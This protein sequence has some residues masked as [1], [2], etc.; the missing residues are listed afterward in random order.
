ME[1]IYEELE[2]NLA[3]ELQIHNSLLAAAHSFNNAIKNNDLDSLQKYTIVYDEHICQIEKL[4]EN[5]IQ[6]CK[7][8]SQTDS[9]SNK[10]V[11][12]DTILKTAP[13]NI[14][15]RIHEIRSSLKEKIKHLYRINTSNQILIQEAMNLI[16]TTFTIVGNSC[17]KLSPYNGKGK[18]S[19]HVSS[20][21]RI[22]NQ[23]A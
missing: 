4:E 23:I 8:L 3:Q 21:T 1:K 7:D 22:I 5:R 6:L 18:E 11:K 13:E 15:E 10:P 14:K 9:S 16:T 20:T 12:L 2:K 19:S 17:N